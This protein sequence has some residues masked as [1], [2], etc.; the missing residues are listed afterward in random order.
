[1]SKIQILALIVL[2]I[3]VISI[4][5]HSYVNKEKLLNTYTYY[6]LESERKKY[7]WDTTIKRTKTAYLITFVVSGLSFLASIYT[8]LNEKIFLVLI[9]LSFLGF[10]FLSKPVKK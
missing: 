2:I 8:D 5:F 10:V 7:D 4:F 3:S 9:I 6:R 1:M